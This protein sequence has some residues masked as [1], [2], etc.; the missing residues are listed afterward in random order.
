MI[1]AT[2]SASETAERGIGVGT[3]TA[4]EETGIGAAEEAT[5]VNTEQIFRADLL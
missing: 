4:A 3:E 2:A 5:G 1:A